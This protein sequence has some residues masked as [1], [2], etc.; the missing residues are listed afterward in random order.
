ME[1]P[2]WRP[3][4]EVYAATG[5]VVALVISG[6]IVQAGNLPVEVYLIAS[7]VV[8]T[9]SVWRIRKGVMVWQQRG[10]LSGKPLEWITTS[11]IQKKMDSMPDHVWLGWGFEWDRTHMQRLYDIER[12]GRK[13]RERLPPPRIFRRNKGPK[14]G[15]P[16]LHGVEPNEKDI[17]IPIKDWEGHV[18]VPAQT[19]AIK[20]RL[21]ALM[22]V[23][24][25]RRTPRECVIIIDP[26]YDHDLVELVE[27]ECKA[28]GRGGDFA[29]FHPA[30]PER[31]VRLDPLRTWARTTE[32]A[33]RIDAIVPREGQ[34]DPFAAFSWRVVNLIT[35]GLIY[36][37]GERPLLT[38]I[39]RYVDGGVDGLVHKTIAA[40][41]EREGIDWNECIQ[42]FMK[43]VARMQK[44]SPTT[45]DETMALVAY[46]KTEIQPKNT[47][48]YVD[49]LISM[50]EHDREHG[51]KMISGLM[52]LLTML[53]AGELEMLLSP[54]RDDPND[55]RPILDATK[56]IQG[57]LVV[58]IGLDT[59]SDAVVGN[60]I[61]SLLLA[62]ITSVS[63]GR[64]KRKETL[65]KVNVFID[66]ANQVANPPLIELMNKSRSA[67]FT[68][69]LFSQ[70][71]SDFIAKLGNES[72]ARQVLGNANSTVAGRSKDQVTMDYIMETFGRS[73]LV[74]KQ[75]AHG[76]NTNTSGLDVLNYGGSYG[77]R[78]TETL[79]EVVPPEALAKLPDLE[80]FATFSGGRIIKGRIPLI[81]S[82]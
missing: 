46:Y 30:F 37:L 24:A 19:G 25:I 1:N 73:I 70:L 52:P 39:R 67:G 56:I 66:E 31:S 26:K 75:E 64:A 32:V 82:V 76:T 29:F 72:M 22:A 13:E 14:R 71:V 11:E 49:G 62:E 44:P 15:N 23:Q 63:G 12:L 43:Q 78:T 65:P 9:L 48:G 47:I 60:A 8:L 3:A 54:D 27:A 59:L 79:S 17:F 68:A 51:Q 38:S 50:F 45:P 57:G 53:T 36:G 7:V 80:Y 28:V 41:L 10:S 74:S 18:F 58:Y 42:P 16:M 35:E 2:C 4:Y 5:W 20:T 77:V 6:F 34:G 69:V 33:S 55:V 81:R 61:G 40:V 21:L